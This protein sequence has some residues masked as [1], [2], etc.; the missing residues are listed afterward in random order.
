MIRANM[1][2]FIITLAVI[3]MASLQVESFISPQL[4]QIK[5]IEHIS[6]LSDSIILSSSRQDNLLIAKA[7][8]EDV[9]SDNAEGFL[10]G[11]TINPP[12]AIA[13]VFFVAY[14]FLQNSAEGDSGMSTALIQQ[15]IADPM[16]P[17]FNELFITVFNLLGLY[18]APLACLLLPGAKGQK[19]PAT[20]FVLGSMAGGYG[21]FGIYAST[22]KPNASIVSTSDL[23]WF[24]ANVLENKIFNYLIVAAFTS[25]YIT[26]KVRLVVMKSRC[27]CCFM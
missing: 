11:F 22:R 4:N 26:R 21:L 20:P 18:A 12:Y 19:L 24:T 1:R 6:S 23:G 8:K 9:S 27:F 14:A 15:Y 10:D 25:A 16:N 3:C 13:Y 7:T 2:G 17:G 5:K